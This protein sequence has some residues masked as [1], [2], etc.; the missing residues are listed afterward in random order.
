MKNPL[1]IGLS[2]HKIVKQ[3]FF[4]VKTRLLS[5]NNFY[6]SQYDKILLIA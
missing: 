6:L 1:D 2:A 3:F 4:A 5:K